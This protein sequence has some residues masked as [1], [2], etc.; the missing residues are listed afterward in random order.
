M[1]PARFLG[2]AVVTGRFDNWWV[3]IFAPIVGATLGASLAL[4]QDPY[5]FIQLRWS[6]PRVGVH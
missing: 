1:N 4:L 5:C 6:V 3:Y 2:P